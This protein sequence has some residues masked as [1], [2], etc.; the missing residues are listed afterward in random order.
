[1]WNSLV[2]WKRLPYQY[3]RAVQAEYNYY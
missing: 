2:L 3:T 1:M